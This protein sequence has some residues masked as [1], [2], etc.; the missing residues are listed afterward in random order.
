MTIWTEETLIAF[1]DDIAARFE[2]AEIPYPVHLDGGN[3]QGLID[4]FANH[5]NVGDWV[6]GTWRMHYKCLLAG[7]P[8]GQVRQAILDGHS[9]TLCFPEYRI[10][11]SAL[12][13]HV[14]SI[15]MGIAYGMYREFEGLSPAE[16]HCFIG[17]MTATTG[18]FHEA[19]TYAKGHDL[20]L[21][22]I[23]EDNKKS[24]TT[25]TQET[26][27]S[28]Y[29]DYVYEYFHRIEYTPKW[30]HQGIGKRVDF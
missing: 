11:S 23:I 27:G 24:V 14:C 26:W 30:P 6:C 21:T 12:V 2:R 1:E 8:E 20:P 25:D 16:V 15:A 4:Y 17:D 7:V 18:M 22:F 5:F 9:I 19:W 10:F 13:G 29:D 28:Y 3:E